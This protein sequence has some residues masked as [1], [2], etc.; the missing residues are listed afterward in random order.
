MTDNRPRP[1]NLGD[2]VAITIPDARGGG[3]PW[4]G[5]GKVIRPQSKVVDDGPYAAPRVE[6]E[7]RHGKTERRHFPPEWIAKPTE[8]A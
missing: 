2:P 7:N 8:A 3:S 6:F 1:W 4:T 5:V